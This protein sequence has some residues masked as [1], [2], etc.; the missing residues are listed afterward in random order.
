MI[1]T[2]GATYKIIE[3]N[4]IVYTGYERTSL[5][6]GSDYQQSVQALTEV[7]T[8]TTVILKAGDEYDTFVPNAESFT[9]MLSS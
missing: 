3:D 2:S 7:S 1:P 4:K 5:T 6:S 8:K 9:S